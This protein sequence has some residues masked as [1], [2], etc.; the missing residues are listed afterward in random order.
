MTCEKQA[1]YRMQ[2]KMPLMR[3]AGP[4]H[5]WKVL[6]EISDSTVN[7]VQLLPAKAD[8]ISS[9]PQGGAHPGHLGC[10]S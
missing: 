10:S 6:C 8:A 1:D 7:P 4:G 5:P 3:R 9:L 2:K